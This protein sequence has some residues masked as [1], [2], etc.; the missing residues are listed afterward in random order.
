MTEKKAQRIDLNH[1]RLRLYQGHFSNINTFNDYSNLVMS[2]VLGGW[3]GKSCARNRSRS[4]QVGGQRCAAAAASH[5]ASAAAG[6]AL[7]TAGRRAFGCGGRCTTH[8]A[9][10]ILAY[11][12]K[13][14][15]LNLRVLLN[16]CIHEYNFNDPLTLSTMTITEKKISCS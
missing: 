3:S 1:T 8:L 15:Y 16:I 13:K 12:K 9:V 6:P 7:R 14:Q 10:F 11:L 2:N 5:T 4:A